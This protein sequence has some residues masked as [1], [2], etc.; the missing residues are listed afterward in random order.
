[1]TIKVIYNSGDSYIITIP[2]ES[3]ADNIA[4]VF[5]SIHTDCEWEVQE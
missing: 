2:N 4:C 3:Y 1:M 5:D